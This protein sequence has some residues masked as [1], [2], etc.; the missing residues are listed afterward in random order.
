MDYLLTTPHF[1]KIKDE[2]IVLQEY[3]RPQFKRDSYISLNGYWDYKITTNPNDL[4]G[5]DSKIRVPFPLESYASKVQKTLKENEYLIYHTTF[6]VNK[7]FIKD[8][9][10]LH[11]LGV[12]QTFKRRK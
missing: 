7:D 8:K 5:F 12:D 9:T 4:S 11:F 10:L 1:D 6:K 3:P 2:D